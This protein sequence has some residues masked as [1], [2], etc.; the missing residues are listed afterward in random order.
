MSN[1]E[2]KMWVL[3]DSST[4]AYESMIIYAPVDTKGMQSVMSG[5]DSSSIAVLPSGFSIL[6]DG[7]ESR[8]MVITSRP[9]EKSAEGGSLLTMA[10]QILI[11]NTPTTKL[12]VDSVE[13]VNTLISC[14]LQNIKTTLQ[15]ED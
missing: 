9:E 7:I 6:P 8:A 15:C 1:E 2:Q 5:C 3:Q 11:S 4:N 10:F 14:T 13:S 12:S